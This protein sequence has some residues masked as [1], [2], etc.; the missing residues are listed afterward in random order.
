MIKA[1]GKG[2]AGE[3]VLIIGLN[4]EDAE[5][6]LRGGAIT[7]PIMSKSGVQAMVLLV[8]GESDEATIAKLLSVRPD[9]QIAARGLTPSEKIPL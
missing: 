7:T 4:R 1:A 9:V 6:L 2:H 8:G 5:T 3:P